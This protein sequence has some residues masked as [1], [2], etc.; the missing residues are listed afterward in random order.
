RLENY[1]PREEQLELAR[2]VDRAIRDRHHLIV[3]AGTG[4]GKSFAYLVPAILASA[5][6]EAP[7]SEEIP[8]D[9]IDDP[10]GPPNDAPP[11]GS[12]QPGKKPRTKVVI[13]TNTISLQEQIIRKDLPFLNSIIPL[14][15][16]AV[17]VKGRRNYL[18][19]RRLD[20]AMERSLSLFAR[21]EEMDELEQIK[22]WSKSTAD[23]SLADLEYKPM[24]QVWDEV[25]CDQGN[26]L[27]RNCAH[28]EPCFYYRARRRIYNAQ[29]LIVNHALLFS[30][31]ALR[32]QGV[33]LLP[34]YDV[35][36]LDEAHNVE[37][38][39]GDH[40]GLSITS[41]QVQYTLNKLYNDRANKGLLVHYDLAAE[42]RQVLECHRREDDFFDDIE[43]WLENQS[44]K[45]GRVRQ[46]DIVENA[47]SE[48]LDA[49]AGMVR[50]QGRKAKN[51]DEAQDF[52]A[53][54][55]RLDAMALAL[56]EWRGQ[57]LEDAVYWIE[58]TQ[59]RGYR[60]VTLSA[61][62]INVGAALRE[63][64]F[65]KVPTVVMTSA[66]LA[67]GGNSFDYF[68]S[69]IG[70]TQCESLCLG[71]PFD[72]KSQ[73]KLVL[74]EGMPDPAQNA[75]LYERKAAEM[76]QRYVEQTDG[77]AF[78]LFTSYAM[79]RRVA[80]LVTPWLAR[81]NMALFNQA[82]GRPRTRM[83]ADFKANRRAV[84]FGTDSFWQGVDVPGDALV[85]VIITRLPFAVPDHPLVEARLEAI[86]AAG[87]NPFFEY[88]LPAA[89]IKLKQ[90][91]GRLIRSRRDTGMVVILDP[92]VRTKRYGK[93][94]L[95][96]LPDCRRVVEGV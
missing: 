21:A 69:R 92:R 38:V 61:S 89:A 39:A 62:P 53:A 11:P 26:C 13:A 76:V 94:F 47:L 35:V 23:G 19:Q 72:Y 28:Y 10:D 71:S 24:G 12:N 84:L 15:F 16:T 1:E 65:E 40:L 18:C 55:N 46:A 81:K 41:G 50:K 82:D 5:S 63:Q 30:D 31:L 8:P 25:A 54:A 29:V 42:Q 70:L 37:A 87:G 9:E 78:V 34:D 52:V 59:R 64:L 73:A 90:G 79:M 14:E 86:K 80:T 7:T 88:Q 93:V 77:R 74:T 95:D 48:G 36:I 56:E 32:Q 66:T 83:L 67:T 17:L 2:A 58:K 85:N 49:L 75:D 44:G 33:K 57:R 51:E 91:F 60:R 43:T 68:K 22:D 20:K 4:V 96:S 27:G 3:E 6:Q 45:N